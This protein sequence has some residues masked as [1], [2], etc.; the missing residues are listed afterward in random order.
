MLALVRRDYG[1]D[2]IRVK[3][4]TNEL[5]TVEWRQKGWAGTQSY[6]FTIQDAKQAQLV[7]AGGNWAK[8]PAAM[9]RARCISAVARMAF[10]E[11]IAG[12]YSP[13]ELGD[14]V[15]VTDEGEV[16]SGGTVPVA[17]PIADAPDENI[18]DVE[19]RPVTTTAKDE[20]RDKANRRYFAVATEYGFTDQGNKLFA[21]AHCPQR[22]HGPTTSRKQLTAQELIDLADVIDSNVAHPEPDTETGELLPSPEVEFANAI[23]VAPDQKRLA[24]IA[25]QLKDGGISAPWLRKMWAHRNKEVPPVADTQSTFDEAPDGVAGADRFTA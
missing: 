3:E 9:L 23:A 8:Y 14:E 13:G 12:M 20:D 17:G 16:V 10:P 4:T 18:V 24:Q 1:T 11:S 15:V 21:L 22:E 25:A 5:C 2:A 6:T 7:V 19:S